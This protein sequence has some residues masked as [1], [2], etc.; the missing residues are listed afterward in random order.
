MRAAGVGFLV[1]G[2]RESP[3]SGELGAYVSAVLEPDNCCGQI[4]VG[5]H[6]HSRRHSVCNSFS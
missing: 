5:T 3:T 4:R 1:A 2:G 6:R